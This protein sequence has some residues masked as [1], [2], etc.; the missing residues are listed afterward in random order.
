[1]SDA[2][3]SGSD[4]DKEK[5]AWASYTAE[6]DRFYLRGVDQER[7]SGDLNRLSPH[8]FGKQLEVFMTDV[9]IVGASSLGEEE[10]FPKKGCIDRI[11]ATSCVLRNRLDVKAALAK[12]KPRL[13]VM[14]AD[15][16]MR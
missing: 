12:P 2:F 7:I 6:V 8:L 4:T 14:F 11:C 16:L 10:E 5:A 1:M 3:A 15:R 13:R 9:T